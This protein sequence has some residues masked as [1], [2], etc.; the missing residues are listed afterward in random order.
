[1]T[2][3]GRRCET[4]TDQLI[5]ASPATAMERGHYMAWFYEILSKDDEVLEAS[6]PVYASAFEAQY[7]AY[8]RMKEKPSLFGPVPT[9]GGKVEGGLHSVAV[10]STSIRAK[11]K[12]D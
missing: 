6:E 8:A 10:A 11:Q 12:H 4:S 9:T 3:D 7:G 5:F 2:S 1:M